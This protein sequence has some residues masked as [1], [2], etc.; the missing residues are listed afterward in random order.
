MNN[1]ETIAKDHDIALWHL[2]L[3]LG[4]E[5]YTADINTDFEQAYAEYSRS[6]HFDGEEKS[7]LR[8]KYELACK[9]ALLRAT[10]IEEVR[11]IF[12]RTPHE[13]SSRRMAVMRWVE[14]AQTVAELKEVHNGAYPFV[15]ARYTA[16]Q[17]W[18]EASLRAIEQTSS[19]E[20]LLRLMKMIPDGEEMLHAAF[21]RGV[22]LA[23][24]VDQVAVLFGRVNATSSTRKIVLTRWLE[25]AKSVKELKKLYKKCFD[26][27]D[28]RN[29]ALRKLLNILQPALA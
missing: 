16:K 3:A 24:T 29:E 2:K 14:L 20:G 1:L 26:E 17:K 27:V 28:I 10:T 18:K 12:S 11:R 5:D 19:F 9:Q 22:V 21:Q 4:E 8:Y 23:D 25:L 15:E 7:I 6:H 13:G